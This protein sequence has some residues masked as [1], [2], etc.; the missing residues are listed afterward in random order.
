MLNVLAV[1]LAGGK[2]ARL[3][4]LIIDAK[5]SLKTNFSGAILRYANFTRADLREA[6][7]SKA[8]LSYADLTGADLTNTNL[9]DANLEKTKID[10]AGEKAGKA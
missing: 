6:D 7:F 8:D 10:K 5:R 2:G 1:I 4:P 9:K 3:E